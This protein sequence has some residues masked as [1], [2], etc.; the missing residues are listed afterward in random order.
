MITLSSCNYIYDPTTTPRDRTKF[1]IYFETKDCILSQQ[2]RAHN[3]VEHLDSLK[4]DAERL[5]DE[6]ARFFKWLI[7]H[8]VSTCN[9]EYSRILLSFF[10]SKGLLLG[11]ST[12]DNPIK[13]LKHR[14]LVVFS[15]GKH[16]FAK[17]DLNRIGGWRLSDAAR[18][19]EARANKDMLSR[20]AAS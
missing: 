8:N 18:Q 12:V 1:V 17:Q 9:L 14:Y 3:V 20:M 2:K 11:K 6:S 19:A 15:M 4:V 16:V 13:Q 7:L 5:L 10:H